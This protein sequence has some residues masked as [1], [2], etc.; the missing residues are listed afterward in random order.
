MALTLP[1]LLLSVRRGCLGEG[2]WTHRHPGQRFV[3]QVKLLG[4]CQ[5][6]RTSLRELRVTRARPAA[7]SRG[8]ACHPPRLCHFV[9]PPGSLSHNSN[10]GSQRNPELMSEILTWKTPERVR[11]KLLQQPDALS[12]TAQDTPSNAD[13][14][15]VPHPHP[16]ASG[17]A[18]ATCT[19]VCARCSSPERCTCRTK[20]TAPGGG[21]DTGQ[22]STGS[23]GAPLSWD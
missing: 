11:S 18:E 21:S 5:G 1:M 19:P 12:F 4:C 6:H 7:P 10:S 20:A 14:F 22:L 17:H 2:P 16:P 15:Q 8:F 3:P 13:A 23:Q 9:C